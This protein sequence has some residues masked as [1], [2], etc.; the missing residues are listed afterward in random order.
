LQGTELLQQFLEAAMF[1]VAM[2]T[3][4]MFRDAMFSDLDVKDGPMETGFDQ[5]PMMTKM[6]FSFL[7]TIDEPMIFVSIGTGIKPDA[8][9]ASCVAVKTFDRRRNHQTLLELRALSKTATQTS[10]MGELIANT[11]ARLEAS[12]IECN[13][14]HL[15]SSNGDPDSSRTLAEGVFQKLCDLVARKHPLEPFEEG[16]GHHLVDFRTSTRKTQAQRDILRLGWCETEACD[17]S[18]WQAP[19]GSG[20][21]PRYFRFRQPLIVK[22]DLQRHLGL[23]PLLSHASWTSVVEEALACRQA[24]DLT[25]TASMAHMTL[26][27]YFLSTR[28]KYKIR[29]DAEARF[30]EL[31]LVDSKG[32]PGAFRVPA[33]D[34]GWWHDAGKFKRP[35]SATH[36]FAKAGVMLLSLASM[37]VLKS[38]AVS[39]GLSSPADDIWSLSMVGG[40]NE[41]CIFAEPESVEYSLTKSSTHFRSPTGLQ[42]PIRSCY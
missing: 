12:M 36:I 27:Q 4:A 6:D 34:H 31:G 35:L 37:H 38:Y 22:Q 28:E 24:D 21:S 5:A 18:R 16:R 10:H 30:R 23:N 25:D 1:R 14:N 33:E 26:R 3:D 11:I 32:H 39:R 41:V 40:S 29:R 7:A 20:S 42:N 15:G 2:F 13:E 8:E 9:F 17:G 19:H